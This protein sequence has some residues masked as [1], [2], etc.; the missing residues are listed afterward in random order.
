MI[1]INSISSVE[2]VD[3][4]AQQI[5]KQIQN[6]EDVESDGYIELVRHYRTLQ[7]LRTILF[8]EK[9]EQE[10]SFRIISFN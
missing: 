3:Q 9:V 4:L 2:Q 7:E 1:N 5:Y 10:S 8:K 6:R